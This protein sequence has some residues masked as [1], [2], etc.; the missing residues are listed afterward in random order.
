MKITSSDPLVT[1]ITVVYNGAA[2]IEQTIQSVINQ[3]YKNIE[4]IIIDGASTDG[5]QNIISQYK[6]HVAYFL[7]EKDDGLYDAMNK[8]IQHA[9]GDI[10]GIIN[11]D[12]WY[13]PDAVERAVSC[14]EN[15]DVDV[16]YGEIWFIGVNGE[17]EDC[18][19]HSPF[20]QHPSTFI[21]RSAYQKYG[22]YNTDYR[23][24][25]D[26]ELL[27]RFIADGV[28]F[29]HIDRVLANFRKTGISSI[30]CME[31]AKEIYE[32][33]MK[34]LDKCPENVLDKENI[35]ERFRRDKMLH[36]SE[37]KPAVIREALSR[38]CC[39]SDG[40][41]VF[42][43]GV[44]GKECE[45]AFR[46]SG[47][48][49]R[50]FVDNDENKWG[51]ELKGKRIFSPEILRFG[52]AHV[53]VTPTR[54]QKEICK[55]LKSYSNPGITWSILDEIRKEAVDQYERLMK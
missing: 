43:T 22:L 36:I 23:I 54:F 18:T 48:P 21:R 35:E 7:S 6:E 46:K 33:D 15:P 3:T 51:L 13:E 34:Y 9:N 26:R 49:I 14:F 11:S 4:Y 50:F 37:K 28:R 25:A 30:E 8:G 38:F 20:P 16:A 32:A 45:T 44:F 5:T 42:G 53:I 17:I 41:V 52:N 1:V 12:D 55:Q 40:L 29:A 27:L 19:K 2:T 39:I 10:I 24:A 31:C 47:I